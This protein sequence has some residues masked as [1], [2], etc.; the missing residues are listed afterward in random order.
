[1]DPSAPLLTASTLHTLIK[2]RLLAA[3]ADACQV[4][5]VDP[6]DGSQRLVHIVHSNPELKL[7]IVAFKDPQIVQVFPERG[8][9]VF[10]E[11]LFQRGIWTLT[12]DGARLRASLAEVCSFEHGPSGDIPIGIVGNELLARVVRGDAV[13][14]PV[15]ASLAFD[16]HGYLHAL[17]PANLGG[18]RRWFH[19]PPPDPSVPYDEVPSR[20]LW[21]CP[22][23]A[24]EA[25]LL[26]LPGQNAYLL[27][28]QDGSVEF[29]SDGTVTPVIFRG[30][31]GRI[32]QAW[33]SSAGAIALLVSWKSRGILQHRLTVS[34]RIVFTGSFRMKADGFRWSSDGRHFAALLTHLGEKGK[35]D[36]DTIL[37]AHGHLQFDQAFVVR[38]M[39]VD[40]AGY[41]AYLC[42]H[43]E[44][45]AFHVRF[46]GAASQ[47]FP[48]AW[49]L[50]MVG[51]AAVANVL[52]E[53]GRICRAEIPY[54]AR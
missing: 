12:S 17:V 16:G 3:S 31:D 40:N 14:L 46:Q 44:T 25:Q 43:S 45:G 2:K 28:K 50:S 30:D 6:A 19:L 33:C 15:D 10:G 1:V 21:P 36:V 7:P 4:A 24:E 5:R 41:V 38:E 27:Q 39:R 53:R 47:A 13:T 26:I 48:Y 42:E 49:N 52:D 9:T 8:V 34:G 11:Y 32:E 51:D 22:F 54:A 35:P 37:T 18:D 20:P 29:W 23:D